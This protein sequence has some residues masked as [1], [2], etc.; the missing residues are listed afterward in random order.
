MRRDFT[1]YEFQTEAGMW[2]R[3]HDMRFI[4]FDYQV[5]IPTLTLRFV[6]DDPQW[7][8]PEARA[9]PV[10]VLSFREVLVH[11]W[12]D[13][14]DL[15][16]TPIEVRGQVGALDYLSSSNEFSLNTVN[17]RLRFSARSLEVHL[18]PVEDA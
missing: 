12:E 3:L 1:L 18:E 8:P 10:A 14:D 11:A 4:G 6:Y 17:T 9:T 13:D 5:Q 7:T 2:V 16:G 15:L